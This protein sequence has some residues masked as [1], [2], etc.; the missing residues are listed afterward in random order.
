MDFR[1]YIAGTATVYFADEAIIM[2]PGSSFS[3]QTHRLRH[4]N[5]VAQK[6]EDNRL[7][8][9]LLTRYIQAASIVQTCYMEDA[10]TALSV[11]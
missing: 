3:V 1:G 11:G 4:R 5:L 10:Q 9:I 7:K 2:T 8:N 6:N